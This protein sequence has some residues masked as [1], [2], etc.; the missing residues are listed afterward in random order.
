M[1]A[2]SLAWFDAAPAALSFQ[3]DE[4]RPTRPVAGWWLAADAEEPDA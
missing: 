3:P 4:R 1:P 2:D